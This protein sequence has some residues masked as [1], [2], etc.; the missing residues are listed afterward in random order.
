M[1]TTSE[2]EARV[3]ELEEKIKAMEA[4][5]NRSGLR[6]LLDELFPSDVRM[7]MRTAR[8]EQLMAIRSMLDHWID[9]Q[10]ESSSGTKRRETISVD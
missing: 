4:E 9:K 5:G 7:H 3:R 10:D 2:L 1:A 8:K 6:S